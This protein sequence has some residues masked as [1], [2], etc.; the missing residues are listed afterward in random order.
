MATWGETAG[1]SQRGQTEVAGVVVLQ[2]LGSDGTEEQSRRKLP[3]KSS[4]SQ[5][6]QEEDER[7]TELLPSP[8]RPAEGG[9]AHRITDDCQQPPPPWP[10]GS[11]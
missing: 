5:T 6:R 8:P 7:G 4:L 11:I 1:E 3:E 2:L 9:R 10:H